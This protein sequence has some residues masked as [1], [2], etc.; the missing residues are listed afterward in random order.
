MI[1]CYIYHI[2]LLFRFMQELFPA[3]RYEI[4]YNHQQ[5]LAD[6][7]N[8]R[9]TSSEDDKGIKRVPRVVIYRYGC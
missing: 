1:D 2:C 7:N 9:T 6:Y 5:F 4:V 8:N 3:S